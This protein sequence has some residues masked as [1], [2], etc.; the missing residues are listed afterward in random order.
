MPLGCK[1][2]DADEEDDSAG[3]GEKHA[4]AIVG[5]RLKVLH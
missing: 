1:G 4:I 5:R 2:V 3:E